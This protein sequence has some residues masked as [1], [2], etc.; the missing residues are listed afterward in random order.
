MN[1]ARKRVLVVCMGNICRSPAGENILRHTLE[2]RGL[3]DRVEVDSAGT[4]GYH[5]G[6]P[7]DARMRRSLR[8]RGYP[9]G[10]RARQVRARDL[11]TFDLVL[12]AD[13][14]N[15]RDVRALSKDPVLLAK[16]RLLCDYHPEPPADRSVPD[17]Y[18]GGPQGFE[19]VIDLIEG[20][21][22]GVIR[23]LLGRAT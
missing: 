5:E 18:Y 11:E 7:P 9:D 19:D 10:G 23:E 22:D 12:C 17:P 1:P 16:V 6:D 3:G 15:L 14:A 13:H 20:C 21:C 2:R 4:I 8:A